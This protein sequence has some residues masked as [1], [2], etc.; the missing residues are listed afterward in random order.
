MGRDEKFLDVHGYIIHTLNG[1]VPGNT[2]HQLEGVESP[3]PGDFFED[4]MNFNQYVVVHYLPHIGDGKDR[5]HPGGGT[6]DNRN[7]ACGS[8][9]RNGGIPDRRFASLFKKRARE[10]RELTAFLCQVP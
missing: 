7:G 8:Y 10:I 6:G 4:G 3:F 5:F 9:G 2:L 1:A